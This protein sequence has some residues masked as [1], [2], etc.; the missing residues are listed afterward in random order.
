MIGSQGLAGEVMRNYVEH[1]QPQCENDH[2][3]VAAPSSLLRSD[4]ALSPAGCHITINFSSH[5]D[6]LTFPI[7][8]KLWQ[9]VT[10]LQSF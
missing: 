7:R 4:S 8:F 3:A 5:A 9:I 2:N 10:Q 1:V 6:R